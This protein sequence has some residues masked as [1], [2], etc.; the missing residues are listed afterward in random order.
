MH[1]FLG[2]HKPRKNFI[3]Q[4]VL[5]CFFVS[6][7]IS[8]NKS[9]PVEDGESTAAPSINV[10]DVTKPALVDM[11]LLKPNKELHHIYRLHRYVARYRDII[12]NST[13]SN[14][15][16]RIINNNKTNIQLLTFENISKL[17]IF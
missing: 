9:Q 7:N 16:L 12:H 1:Y 4:Q 14:S 2:R 8:F 17:N 6:F 13:H 10:G 5:Y 3:K 11:E 15:I